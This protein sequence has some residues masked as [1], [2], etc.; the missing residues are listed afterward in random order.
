MDYE[1]LKEAVSGCHGVF[2][3]A[4]P[5]TDD[6]VSSYLY[7]P[8]KRKGKKKYFV[9][10]VLVG[11]LSNDKQSFPPTTWIVESGPLG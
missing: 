4:S 1:S 8:P 5:V 3:T 10:G 2:H 7:F 11:G 9:L 6:P